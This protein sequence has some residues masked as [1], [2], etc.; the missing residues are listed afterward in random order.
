MGTLQKQ[1]SNERAPATLLFRAPVGVFK[2]SRV[3]LSNG[4]FR[5]SENPTSSPTAPSTDGHRTASFIQG[6]SAAGRYELSWWLPF[7]IAAWPG[8]LVSLTHDTAE[9]AAAALMLGA[10]ACYFSGRL[11][12]YCVIAAAASLTRETTLPVLLGLF[13]NELY[14]GIRLLGPYRFGRPAACGV[15]LLP[16]AGWV[17][18]LGVIWRHSG[19]VLNGSADLGWPLVGVATMLFANL[20]GAR[21]W[22]ADPIGNIVTKAFVVLTAFGLIGFCTAVVMRSQSLLRLALTRGLA[23]GWL[24][25]VC[26]MSLLTAEGPWGEPQS[27]FRALTE[28]WVVG[29]L[30]LSFCPP[31][32]EINRTCVVALV[33]VAVEVDFVTWKEC[34]S[35]LP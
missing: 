21:T 4:L 14:I 2:G 7:A 25:I 3:Q 23:I 18:T 17:A 12:N 26:L 29:C 28:C 15:A 33:C 5:T 10:L 19:E 11:A 27:Y 16:L 20:S 35:V 9:I 22:N 13:A 6:G 34:F 1:K 8:F 32:G 24:L 30:L 31:R